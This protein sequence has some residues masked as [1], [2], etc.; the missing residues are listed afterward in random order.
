MPCRDYGSDY[1]DNSRNYA[2]QTKLEL[3]I[4]EQKN[5]LDMLARIACEAMT[6]LQSTVDPNLKNVTE[7]AKEWFMK[8]QIA[9]KKEKQRIEKLEKKK[10][11]IAEQK[12]L[13]L[14]K[15]TP[16]E[17]KALKIKV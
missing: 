11:E 8:H 5:R 1:D 7:E 14:K 16:E 3:A 10:K 2:N 13:A 4:A 12:R 17:I 9:D 15:L 6:L